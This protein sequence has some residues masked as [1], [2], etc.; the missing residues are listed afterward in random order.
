MTPEGDHAAPRRG[1]WG[2]SA[3]KCAV[4]GSS[5]GAL[6]GRQPDADE[7]ED[8]SEDASRSSSAGGDT[9][10]QKKL[11]M[12]LRTTAG[13]AMTDGPGGELLLVAGTLPA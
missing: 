5:K 7:M 6:T 3:K 1:W 2:T 8:S 4:R 13:Q 12:I 10:Y 9:Y 11:L